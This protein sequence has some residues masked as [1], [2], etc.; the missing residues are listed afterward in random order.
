MICRLWV[1]FR[2]T[3]F[4]T[5][6]EVPSAGGLMGFLIL[7]GEVGEIRVFREF[8][9]EGIHGF[10]CRGFADEFDIGGADFGGFEAHSAAGR[11]A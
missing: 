5:E 6:G 9:T 10:E 2:F 1:G 11:D 7:P 4:A 3:N 8:E